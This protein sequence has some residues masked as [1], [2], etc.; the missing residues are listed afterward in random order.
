MIVGLFLGIF[1]ASTQAALSAQPVS[2]PVS[3]IGKSRCG[4][5][6]LSQLAEAMNLPPKATQSLLGASAG[7]S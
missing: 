2:Q 5:L 6:A 4:P 1:G 3:L 7:G